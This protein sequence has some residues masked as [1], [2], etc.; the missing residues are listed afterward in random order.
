MVYRSHW[1][2]FAADNMTIK[3][4]DLMQNILQKQGLRTDIVY[5]YPEFPARR[6]AAQLSKRLPF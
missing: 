5:Y 3:Y 6:A 2:I 4:W 1:G